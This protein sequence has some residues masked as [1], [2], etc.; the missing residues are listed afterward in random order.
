MMM[1][2]L[3]QYCTST[4]YTV[5]ATALTCCCFVVCA[6]FPRRF[7]KRSGGNLQ[8]SPEDPIALCDGLCVCLPTSSQTQR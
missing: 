2:Y 1:S 3:L 5:H 7:Q 8:A 4:I 6:G